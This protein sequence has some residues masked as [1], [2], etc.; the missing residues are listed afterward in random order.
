MM[1]VVGGSVGEVIVHSAH[2]NP[3]VLDCVDS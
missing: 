2:L 3:G 1:H